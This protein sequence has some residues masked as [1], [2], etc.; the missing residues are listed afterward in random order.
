MRRTLMRLAHKRPH[1]HSAKIG[2]MRTRLPLEDRSQVV[3]WDDPLGKVE[4]GKHVIS[5]SQKY[6]IFFSTE[7]RTLKL[8][9]RYG[10]PYRINVATSPKHCFQENSIRYLDKVEHPYA[11]TI[12]DMY[13]AKKKEPL[14]LY[15]FTHGASP[16][17]VKTANR[18]LAHAMRDALAAAG[19]DRF[20]RRVL[21]DGETSAATD[22]HGTIRIT[23]HDPLAVC[24]AK[25]VDLLDQAKRI[26]ADVEILHVRGEDGLRFYYPR[27]H[28]AQRG[29]AYPYQDSRPPPQQD[30]SRPAPYSRS[31]PLEGRPRPPQQRFQP[32]Q[33]TGATKSSWP[34]SRGKAS[35]FTIKKLRL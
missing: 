30:R 27:T 6:E 17:P 19:Y 5:V 21:A 32:G 18:K 35:S 4:P 12:L 8:D 10:N 20:G 14:W 28:S 33:H 7:L 13:I 31:V 29:V 26:L 24:N 22:L 1:D 9:K 15:C 2:H 16:F 34:E 11:K 3:S 23:G 25:F